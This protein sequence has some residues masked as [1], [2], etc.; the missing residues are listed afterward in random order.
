MTF[1]AEGVEPVGHGVAESVRAY[2]GDRCGDYYG[3][4]R[5][6]IGKSVGFDLGY[7]V[8]DREN[9]VSFMNVIPVYKQPGECAVSYII[10]ERIA[11]KRCELNL[12]IVPGWRLHRQS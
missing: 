4:S 3:L 8:R 5:I 7:A 2:L 9:P 1:Y 12:T 11:V 6:G 10:L